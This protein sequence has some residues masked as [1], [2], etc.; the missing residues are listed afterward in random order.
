MSSAKEPYISDFMAN[1]RFSLS[2]MGQVFHRNAGHKYIP[3][4]FVPYLQKIQFGIIFFCL[5]HI[6]VLLMITVSRNLSIGGGSFHSIL[7]ML[8]TMVVYTLMPFKLVY[9]QLRS[10][11][12]NDLM[13]YMN[14]HFHQRSARGLTYVSAYRSYKWGQTFTTLYVWLLVFSCTQFL[15]DP[16]IS[17][18]R[19]LLLEIFYPFD[20]TVGC[21]DVGNIAD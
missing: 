15:I 8:S 20:E 2:V 21:E 16:I 7:S 14:R 5:Y 17:E 10:K 12:C 4:K 18:E 6:S 1:Q 19:V 13:D 9:F 3:Q 11:Y